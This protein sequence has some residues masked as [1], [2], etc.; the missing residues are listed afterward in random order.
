MNNTD[1]IERKAAY[2]Y[3]KRKKKKK[4]E[5]LFYTKLFFSLCTEVTFSKLGFLM[6]GHMVNT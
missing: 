1:T 3:E 2:F 5:H 4:M 6:G